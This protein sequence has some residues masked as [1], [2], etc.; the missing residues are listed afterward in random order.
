METAMQLDVNWIK[1]YMW[2]LTRDHDNKYNGDTAQND[3]MSE[4]ICH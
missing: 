1:R 2:I 4:K 3:T